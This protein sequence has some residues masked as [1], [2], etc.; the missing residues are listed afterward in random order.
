MGFGP[1]IYDKL[2]RAFTDRLQPKPECLLIFVILFLTVLRA[3]LMVP[4][5]H[6]TLKLNPDA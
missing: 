3:V 4:A 6:A 5:V 2:E 1:R